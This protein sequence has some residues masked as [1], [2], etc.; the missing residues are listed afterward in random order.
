MKNNG[1]PEEDAIT[2]ELL[3]KGGRCLWKNIYQLIVSL[4]EKEILPAEWKTA[5]ICPTLKKANKLGCENYRGISLLNIVHKIFTD[6][7]AQCPKVYTMRFLASIKVDL[8][9]VT[10]LLII[11]LELHKY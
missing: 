6:I 4:W 1:V 2:V 8:G 7:L 3:K 9:K 11:Y 10:A 5:I